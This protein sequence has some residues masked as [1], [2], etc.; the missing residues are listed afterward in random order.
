VSCLGAPTLTR[1]QPLYASTSWAFDT[2]A[3]TGTGVD[4]V[5]F[6]TYPKIGW[7]AVTSVRKYP[8]MLK[9]LESLAASA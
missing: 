8:D 6:W 1:A 5:H 7:G 3:P 2:A 4:N 9:R